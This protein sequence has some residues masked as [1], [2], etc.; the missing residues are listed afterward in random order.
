MRNSSRPPKRSSVPPTL[1]PEKF[2][3]LEQS[4]LESGDAT[5]LARLYMSAAGQ[6]H[7]VG[8]Q[9][10]VLR[11]GLLVLK[12][13]ED[14]AEQQIALR[15]EIVKR[16]PHSLD[17]FSEV[18]QFYQAH[19]K[20]R[21]RARL[22]EDVLAHGRALPE[23]RAFQLRT[24][25]VEIY[26]DQLKDEVQT[27]QLLV[28]L[29]ESHPNDSAL[30]ARA[31][32]VSSSP[33]ALSV[34]GPTLS[35]A[36]E[37][38][39]KLRE[40]L[41]VLSR[42]LEVA[43]GKRLQAVRRR[44]AFLKEDVEEDTDAA[45]QLL[46]SLLL[47]DASDDEVR[48]RFVRISKLHGRPIEG[49]RRLKRAM[50]TVRSLEARARIGLDLGNLQRIGGDIEDAL[51][52]Y[53]EVLNLGLETPAVLSTARMVLEG[54]A[55]VDPDVQA[56]ALSAVAKLDS[57]VQ[58]R[59]QAAHELLELLKEGPRSIDLEK[60]AYRG[61]LDADNGL[62]AI[63]KLEVLARSTRDS[64][65]LS[66]AQEARAARES[67]PALAAK[68]AYKAAELRA[69]SARTSEG[70]AQAFQHY[71]QHYPPNRDAYRKLISIS[72]KRGDMQRVCQ[73]LEAEA[74]I[75][76]PKEKAALLARAGRIREQDLDDV[77][78]AFQA[79]Q[80]SLEVEPGEPT[81]AS[82]LHAHLSGAESLRAAELLEPVY[83]AKD[84]PER[85]LDVLRVKAELQGDPKQRLAA[86]LQACDVAEAQRM[87]PE[88][89]I[90]LIGRALT[91]AVRSDRSKISG[92]LQRLASAD[93]GGEHPG[94]RAQALCQALSDLEIDGPELLKLAQQAASALA[95]AGGFS[96]ATALY[97][98]ALSYDGL[99][100]KTILGLD[101][102][103]ERQ[104][105]SAEVRVAQLELSLVDVEQDVLAWS[106]VQRAIASLRE[107]ELSD[108]DSALEAWQEVIERVPEHLEAHQA[109]VALLKSKG[110][111]EAL[112]SEL[113][114]AVGSLPA[115]HQR[116]PKLELLIL[117]TRQ[118]KKDEAVKLCNE[119]LE[120]PALPA[121][122]LLAMGDLMQKLEN[123]E[124]L[125]RC[126]R[127]SSDRNQNASD[128]ARTLAKLGDVCGDKLGDS[129]GAAA[130]YAEAG[131]VG[132]ADSAFRIDMYEKVLEIEPENRPVAVKLFGLYA[133]SGDWGRVKKGFGA[134]VEADAAHAAQLLLQLE[135]QAIE[136]RQIDTFERLAADAL[137]ALDG[138]AKRSRAL[139]A[140]RARVLASQPGRREET[141]KAFRN[142]V[143]TFGHA[144]DEALFESYL[145]TC[146][147]D[148]GC[149]TDRR[150]LFERRSRYAE[151]KIG[152]LL[153]WAETEAGEFGDAERA[154]S[155]CERIDE[156]KLEDP[157]RLRRLAEVKLACGA[158]ESSLETL[159]LL[160][161]LSPQGEQRDE[162]FKIAALLIDK[163]DRASDGYEKLGQILAE[164]PE[165]PDALRLAEHG[166]E[167][168]EQR[169]FAALAL[170][171]AL[172]QHADLGDAEK[173]QRILAQLLQT[174]RGTDRMRDERKRWCLRLLELQEGEIALK[175]AA[176]AA[177]QLPEVE[178]LWERAEALGTELEQPEPV[179]KAYEQALEACTD[180]RLAE[181]LGKRLL[182]F[183]EQWFG[184]FSALLPALLRVLKIVASARWALDKVV[185][186]L[187]RQQRF[188][189]LFE[190]FN[191][192]LAETKDT[193][194]RAGLLDDAALAAKDLAKD[195][196]LAI[197]YLEALCE[198][199]PGDPRA[200]A[201]LERLYKRAGH[202]RK[203]ITLLTR[204]YETASDAAK[205]EL[206]ERICSLWLDLDNRDEALTFVEQLLELSPGRPSA[207]PL[208]ERILS[209][210]IEA[211]PD[212]WEI[213]LEP[214]SQAA[215]ERAAEL[216]K[217][218][219]TE[220][221][222]DT[223]V[224]RVAEAELEFTQ[225]TQQRAAL[226]RLIVDT[227]Q[228]KL[229]DTQ[230]AFA[231]LCKLVLLVPADVK[232]RLR[233]NGLANELGEHRRHAE[234]LARA[235]RQT[236]VAS[237]A[238]SL[239]LEAAK[240][241]TEK[242]LDPQREIQLYAGVVELNP[243]DRQ[244]L[245]ACKELDRLLS[246]R[247]P[248][249]QHCAILERLSNVETSKARR[250]DAAIRAA[251]LAFS[252][253]DYERAGSN[254][255]SVLE[256]MPDDRE[257]LDGLVHVLGVARDWT[258][259]VSALHERSERV[260]ETAY[261]DRV[262]AAR[263]HADELSDP[264]AS[265]E[266][267]W[268]I[269]N[270]FGPNREIFEALSVLLRRE[271]RWAE[272]SQLLEAEIDLRKGA[273][274]S[275]LYAD[276]G[277]IQADKLQDLRRALDCF[278]RAK[279][280]DRA[281]S[282][283][284]A[285]A[286]TDDAVEL[287]ETL[288]VQALQAWQGGQ[289]EAEVAAY[290]ATSVRASQ[291]APDEDTS[292]RRRRTEESA[293]RAL[294]L[295]LQAKA[296]P[297]ARER[298]RTLARKA[299]LVCAQQLGDPAQALS[300]F[301]ELFRESVSDQVARDSEEQYL[302]LLSESS[303]TQD[304]AE[305]LEYLA[306]IRA[307]H[308]ER[309][310]ARQLWSQAAAAWE[311]DLEDVERGLYSHYRAADLGS[312]QSLQ[313][314]ARLHEARGEGY[315]AALA[316]E[317]VY[318]QAS[319]EDLTDC[320]LRL[321]ALYRDL[322]EEALLKDRLEDADARSGGHAR[323]QKALID[324]YRSE[325]ERA[326]L[327]ALLTA[328]ATSA[329]DPAKELELLSE[330][331][332]LDM[333][334]GDAE[335]AI[336]VLER[337]VASRPDDV[338]LE[339]RL[340]AAYS[341]AGRHQKAITRLRARIES[342]GARQPRSRAD[343]HRQLAKALQAAGDANR[344]LL[345][346]KGAC[347]M[348]PNDSALLGE[349]A[350]LSLKLRQLEQA[351]Q[352][353]RSL[354]LVLRQNADGAGEITRAD[355]YLKLAEIARKKGDNLA[356][357][358]FVE[359]AFETAL[360]GAEAATE[361]ERALKR[362]GDLDLLTS[363]LNGRLERAQS[364]VEIA[365]VLSDL[366]EVLE[367]S[368][369]AFDEQQLKSFAEQ[370]AEGLAI[371]ESDATG[372]QALSL[373]F[374]FL[375][376][377]K[378]RLGCLR[379][380]ID[381]LPLERLTPS[382]AD[383]FYTVAEHE[384]N[385][386]DQADGALAL[387]QQGFSLD[388]MPA[389]YRDILQ[390][391]STRFPDHLEI[392]RALCQA[393]YAPGQDQLLA[394]TLNQLATF[395]SATIWE[396]QCAIDAA[397]AAA[398]PNWQKDVLRRLVARKDATAAEARR[399]HLALVESCEQAAEHAEAAR[400]LRE[401]VPLV[402][403]TESIEILDRLASL[404]ENELRDDL[405][406]AQC[407]SKILELDPDHRGNWER[408]LLA[409]RKAGRID[410]FDSLSQDILPKLRTRQDQA[411]FLLYQAR[412]L[413][414]EP[415]YEAQT[416]SVLTQALQLD[417]GLNGAAKLL[418]TVYEKQGRI[419]ELTEVLQQRL[420]TAQEQGLF[421]QLDSIG[422]QLANALR[423]ENRAPEALQIYEDLL[424]RSPQNLE[425]LRGVIELSDTIPQ[426]N[427]RQERIVQFMEQLLGLERGDK[428]APLAL[429]LAKW[430]EDHDEA[431]SVERTLQT[432]FKKMPS[433]PEIRDRLVELFEQHGQ[434]AMA[435]ETLETAHR[436][437]PKNQQLTLRL[438]DSW[439]HAGAVERA[440]GWLDEQIS[441]N[442]TE[443]ALH[444]KRA[445]IL[446]GT[447]ELGGALESLEAAF[448]LKADCGEALIRVLEA[449]RTGKPPAE[450]L[451]LSLRLVELLTQTGKAVEARAE[452]K[453]L[454]D[455]APDEPRV[456][457]LLA[458]VAEGEKNDAVAVDVYRKLIRTQQGSSLAKSVQ[459]LVTVAERA[460]RL[461]ELP[462]DL[463]GALQRLPAD[464]VLRD[465][466]RSVVE[467]A[468][469]ERE[470]SVLLV[471]DAKSVKNRE[472]KAALLLKAA[473]LLAK[474]DSEES[475]ALLKKA[476][477][478][479]PTVNSAVRLSRSQAQRGERA[480]ALQRLVNMTSGNSSHEAR[481][482]AYQ[483][484]ARLHLA[485]DELVEAYEVLNEAYKLERRNG[486][487]ALLLG[488][489]AL[490]LGDERLA[491]RVLRSVTTMRLRASEGA[492]PTSG[493]RA[494]GARLSSFQT[495]ERGL[496]A[497][498]EEK[499][500]AYILLGEIAKNHGD[501]SAAR[502]L[503]NQAILEDPSNDRAQ[504]LLQALG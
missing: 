411:L 138:D 273:E 119:L 377:G 420:N 141:S 280:Y 371:K 200:E 185:L 289:I 92:L 257:A 255:R 225:E 142:L 186:L 139:S 349:F 302:R 410:D 6:T 180:P 191:R 230:G 145:M 217:A 391:A 496:G 470:L 328:Q 445:E 58:R 503:V 331:A 240:V 356:A 454:Q 441:A 29:L 201:T 430:Y 265:I 223:D 208:L 82:R 245:T 376:D 486:S 372:H 279:T 73:L 475:G 233:L 292:K 161:R 355:V 172:K 243:S 127:L 318:P 132:E 296:L 100:V 392:C 31:Q 480:E 126:L 321:A 306:Q 38:L 76:E 494:S 351:E 43:R 263:I 304:R 442:P 305:L 197:Y 149:Q 18:Q 379:H 405:Q 20:H 330:A 403:G 164:H 182:A 55:D 86:A 322:G 378:R 93:Q 81:A 153:T 231:S 352:T 117:A 384:F 52:T 504:A 219:Y 439:V 312:T 347:E 448:E 48:R 3:K 11:Q 271:G 382:D 148:D 23:E 224:V 84:D 323:V 36:Y 4:F 97:E 56:V 402:T 154:L 495:S 484:L 340:A 419:S 363:A 2:H 247:E 320:A 254:Y 101:Q 181:H 393:A 187:S 276:L 301:D 282:L 337:A 236:D 44:L 333:D 313:D 389:R 199:K 432:A 459:H 422:V 60:A 426:E 375:G 485:A 281:L 381:S 479:H 345:E 383:A 268:Q 369:E 332:A 297:F 387:L 300:I 27:A 8:D 359:S 210:D 237:E 156:S 175:S 190:L 102:L 147:A 54:F 9:V 232:Q 481:T 110:D 412:E 51:S 266:A 135:P 267:W 198:L 401:T 79:Y 344:A 315:Q 491:R 42:E 399:F 285:A 348:S 174:F 25:L 222:K 130:A 128:R 32:A 203:L 364:P 242:L 373:V 353:Y 472:E 368:A 146:P 342:Y 116:H 37:K 299:A 343:V 358:D 429:R 163:L 310:E 298:R 118:G 444:L 407:Y 294:E 346:L 227:R 262:R 278:L 14:A 452:L 99:N 160:Q 476:H 168:P 423:L 246:E 85:L 489:L 155:I 341:A 111:S 107:H 47:R 288:R 478:A 244:V 194:Q 258:N 314:L 204:R 123:H 65:A 213:D 49:T 406:A 131:D 206:L 75:C 272:L 120:D 465:K 221:G 21:E 456:L 63:K 15:H 136:H 7:N 215:R 17:L 1:E 91:E 335:A 177:I 189:E 144:E 400:L 179:Q 291:L 152:L 388:P 433:S 414:T 404:Y 264:T 370:A 103:R 275:S 95:E 492:A 253:G 260:P 413:E 390:Q 137:W 106:E 104:G 19:G 461:S 216:L 112:V 362:A 88:R 311:L 286:N 290:F 188:P 115:E 464:R 408:L 202:T 501:A 398:K 89:V 113:K 500:K 449:S 386:T 211:D 380:Y 70:A 72:E 98:R 329:D 66:Y 436:A 192:A 171:E 184:D 453:K 12:E 46:E 261:R 450:S 395:E 293:Q 458:E 68:L 105:L 385:E 270:Q 26:Q 460:G 212:A 5:R 487:V 416:I 67:D 455:R 34:L 45:Q 13:L 176:D 134:L 61:L 361:L 226:L 309:E 178:P 434:Y 447:G 207:Y 74:K 228:H 205:P 124:L 159:E 425:A 490:D 121:S 498:T 193:D 360:E 256:R 259:L 334:L 437:E 151:D 24:E 57:D 167:D 133:D 418:A 157:E 469:A 499:A 327:S 424:K 122:E 109:I 234:L 396:C 249:E 214:G 468:G 248:S 357:T 462:A 473:D 165:H 62:D 59:H 239:L 477:E 409:Y 307:E 114:R 269:R 295:L 284:E 80:Q 338:A 493:D 417:P 196:E 394:E 35:A 30:L 90:A 252:L 150:W 50:S 158:F 316:L 350:E 129:A 162:A 466:V 325:N 22:I 354:L 287:A 143:E 96:R 77:E 497:S 421:P 502:K 367:Q 474:Y 274:Q 140:A 431:D 53:S 308:G 467:R 235:A 39:G 64:H 94:E 16:D 125:R 303:R 471:Q 220:Q 169:E 427:R 170:A 366:A 463:V 446:E 435:A 443:A 40:E 415:G 457:A 218:F 326:P 317:R 87:G 440:L 324:L 183:H 336:S 83:R 229:K 339:L 374:S 195:P 166:L 365:S 10:H 41:D 209:G 78:G 173:T 428:V 482:A 241:F 251:N 483:E 71:L 438:I 69:K 250:H 319:G 283:V 33:A 238:A 108:N 451:E 28:R 277:E 488:M 397:L